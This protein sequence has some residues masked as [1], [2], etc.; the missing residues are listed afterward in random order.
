MSERPGGCRVLLPLPPRPGGYEWVFLLS[1]VTVRVSW[2]RCASSRGHR[3][4]FAVR[5]PQTAWDVS[6]GD[7]SNNGR[8]GGTRPRGALSEVSGVPSDPGS[9]LGWERWALG[10]SGAI[11][12]VGCSDTVH[13]TASGARAAA[14]P[15]IGTGVSAVLLSRGTERTFPTECFSVDK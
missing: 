3:A 10:A 9:S 15:A 11:L 2:Q 8:R 14:V 7:G 12:G 4:E 13:C 6:E 5:T 1:V